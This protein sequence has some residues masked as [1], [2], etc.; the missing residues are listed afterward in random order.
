VDEMRGPRFHLLDFQILDIGANCQG[1]GDL[2]TQSLQIV[3]A[4]FENRDVWP[5]LQRIRQARGKTSSW[6]VGRQSALY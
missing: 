3:W 2:E 6:G 5:W 1:G 4:G